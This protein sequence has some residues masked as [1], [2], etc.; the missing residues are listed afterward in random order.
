M[1]DVEL[2]QM[3]SIYFEHHIL[4]WKHPNVRLSMK[5]VKGAVKRMFAGLQIFIS[6]AHGPGN[7]AFSREFTGRVVALTI[8]PGQQIDVREHQFSL[9]ATSNLDYGFYF[10]KGLANVFFS[11]SGRIHRHVHGVPGARRAADLRL[12]QRLHQEPGSWRDP[13]RGAGRLGVEGC[14][15]QMTTVTALQSSGGGGGLLGAIGGMMG[16]FLV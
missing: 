4:L 16:G 7:I 2:G 9:L 11:R 13:G 1:A 14:A 15:V 3:Q 8:Q 5:G 10:Q 6:E 12:R